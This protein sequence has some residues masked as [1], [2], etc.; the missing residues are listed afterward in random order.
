[1]IIAY[2]YIPIE[3]GIIFLFEREM[4]NKK[5]ISIGFTNAEDMMFITLSDSHL[6]P[7]DG[8]ILSILEKIDNIFI[9][10]SNPAD[11]K[12]VIQ[13][14]IRLDKLTVGKIIAHAEILKKHAETAGTALT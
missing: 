4:E 14:N 9:A 2:K 5:S 8:E 3:N 6:I 13:N 12:T 1:M 10:A 7:L 11:Y